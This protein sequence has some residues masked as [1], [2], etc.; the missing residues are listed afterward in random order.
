MTPKD[1][2]ISADIPTRI[3]TLQQDIRGGKWASSIESL[4]E[5]IEE[6]AVNTS[7]PDQWINIYLLRSRCYML[8]GVFED[9]TT[10]LNVAN[11]LASTVSKKPEQILSVQNA[12]MGLYLNQAEESVNGKAGFLEKAQEFYHKAA[13]TVKNLGDQWSVAKV[14]YYLTAAHLALIQDNFDEVNR[15]FDQADAGIQD[16]VGT[17]A[18]NPEVKSLQA[19]R[20]KLHGLLSLQR[21]AKDAGIQD[22]RQA[23]EIYAEIQDVRGQSETALI[24]GKHYAGQGNV[25]SG[26]S[27]LILAQ[28]VAQGVDLEPL[29]SKIHRLATMELNKLPPDSNDLV[30]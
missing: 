19:A 27:W 20:L 6:A 9:A 10:D 22:L 29:D 30:E 11:L 8:L 25:A 18:Q 4:T 12:F 13:E 17:Q 5:L 26:R 16:L 1:V 3:A 24:I 15:N 28:K 14:E 2:P 21:E 23:Y 7:Q